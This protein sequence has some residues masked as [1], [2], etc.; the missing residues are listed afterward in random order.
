MPRT[1]GRSTSTATTGICWSSWKHTGNIATYLAGAD[2]MYLRDQNGHHLVS[3]TEKYLKD[4]GL[5]RM[6]GPNDKHPVI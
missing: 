1:S 2:L 5:I 6:K 4:L 3:Q